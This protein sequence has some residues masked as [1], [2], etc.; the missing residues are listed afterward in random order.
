MAVLESVNVSYDWSFIQE[1][2]S[3]SNQFQ[4][5]PNTAIGQ[6]TTTHVWPMISINPIRKLW[7]PVINAVMCCIHETEFV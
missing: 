6:A 3:K 2:K 5:N 1:I 4:S 7:G